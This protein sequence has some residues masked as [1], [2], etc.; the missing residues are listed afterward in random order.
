MAFEVDVQWDTAGLTSLDRML[1]TLEGKNLEKTVD[2]A[3]GKELRPLVGALRSAEQS[4]GIHNR[5]GEHLKKIRLRRSRKRTGEMA[6]WTVGPSDKKK[7]LLVRGHEEIGHRPGKADSGKR[8]RAFPYVEPVIDR[9]SEA[10]LERI[11]SDVWAEALN[12]R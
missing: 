5:T 9:D 8:A 3:M 11:A 2:K 10:I 7:F 1:G 6:A 12:T 4:S